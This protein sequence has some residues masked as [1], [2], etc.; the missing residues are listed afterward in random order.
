[1]R[2]QWV[3]IS[4]GFAI[5]AVVIFH[6]SYSYPN[7]KLFPVTALFGYAWHVPIFFLIGGFFIKEEKLI[8]PVGFIKR[9]IKSLYRLL[10]YFYIP[11][12]LLHNVMLEIGWY[13]TVTDY[14]G[15]FMSEWTMGQTVKELVLSICLAGRE[16][17][18][19]AMWFVYVL[20]M[21]LCGFSLVSWAVRKVVKDD[22]RYE[23]WRLMALLLLCMFSCTASRVFDFTIPRFNN[24]LTAMWLIY[25]GYMIKNRLQW[26]FSNPYIMCL[27]VLV[28][29]HSVTLLG[30]VSL[31]GNYYRDVLSL[32]ITSV[33]A[34]YVICYVSRRIEHGRVGTFLAWCGRDSFYIMGLHFVG[35]KMATYAL[36]L[37]GVD[38]PLSALTAPAGDSI[39]LLVV[40]AV[41]GVLFPLVFMTV[42]R[43]CRQGFGR[44][45][46]SKNQ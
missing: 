33:S 15:K 28:L 18:L 10:L 17:I 26:N 27:S 4:K 34:L 37:F 39:G 35:F 38:C 11:A 32:T 25:C 36:R 41:F 19:G 5:L 9:K 45:F 1:M 20:F 12:V 29:Y 16:P 8:R 24:T 43:W 44:L 13:D 31:N 22:K 21:A 3:D 7:A 6:I 42:F 40:Y 14:G 2:S 30:W 46:L 23:W